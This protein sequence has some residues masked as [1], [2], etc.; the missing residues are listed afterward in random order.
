MNWKRIGISI[1]VGLAVLFVALLLFGKTT[2]DT[3]DLESDL[4]RDAAQRVGVSADQIQVDCPED[5][6]V[7]EGKTFDCTASLEDE[8]VTM[9]VE[10]LDDDGHYRATVGQPEK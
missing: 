7:E 4:A 9:T 5:I 3:G 8:T 2:L 6:E 10:L 1:L